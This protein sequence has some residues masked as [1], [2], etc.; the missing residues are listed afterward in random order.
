M[1]DASRLDALLTRGALERPDHPAV[2]DGTR[3]LTY[4]ELDDLAGRV[5]ALLHSMGV[6]PGWRVGLF[7]DKS[8][9]AVAGLYGI[10]RAG[11]A[12]VP[13][14]VRAP[15]ARVGYIARDCQ[16]SVL[17]TS[18]TCLKRMP[19]L[20]RA[21]APIGKVIVLDG[22]ADGGPANVTVMGQA[23]IDTAV[24]L[25]TGPGEADALA[26]I[27]YTSGSTGQPK[28]V[29]LSHRN[30]L[31]FVEWAADHASVTADD[32][33]S[34]HAPLHF[35]LSVFDL[36]ATALRQATLVLVP[37]SISVFPA[38]LSQWIRD[39]GVTIWYSV[40]SILSMLVERGGLEAGSL[41]S[42]KTV[43]F[44]G[45]VFPSGYLTRL[46]QLV[47]QAT[48]LNWYGPTETNVCTG[49]Q[50]PE[51]PG[52]DAPDIPIGSAI[53]GVAT[54]VVDEADHEVAPGGRGELLVA[55]PTVMQGYWGDSQKTA[56]R[57]VAH[58]VA[59]GGL[60]YRTG[61]LVEE[62]ADG[63]L[64]FLGRRDSQVK[65]RGYRI[66]LGEVETAIRSHPGVLEAAVVAVPDP[67]ITNRLHAHVVL[68][69]AATSVDLVRH[70]GTKVPQYMVPEKWHYWDELPK[71]STGKTNRQA[72]VSELTQ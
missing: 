65:S 22:A 58:P 34:S 49:Y 54:F 32:L 72:L 11:A 48:F 46:M 1:T 56:A 60:V 5:A 61:D 21:G 68:R 2:V 50:V 51:P 43:I 26:Y 70:C 3:T 39:Q 19:A 17:L 59:A 33:L 14:D 36:F 42:L 7:L 9:E 57:L 28:G 44:A 8:A 37:A 52:E 66:E 25:R 16:L 20:C 31:A 67:L 38:T 6:G 27:L 35:D 24:P 45:E 55:G 71:T 47:P 62:S 53:A 15:D 40:P 4:A 10:M 13:L 23:D 69:H 12:Y 18:S 29:M 30:G 64:I 63:N 41:P